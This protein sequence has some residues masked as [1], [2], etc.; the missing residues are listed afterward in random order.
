MT[1][2]TY[3][4]ADQTRIINQYAHQGVLA[5]L[6]FIGRNQYQIETLAIRRAITLGVTEY[7]DQ[8]FHK[9]NHQLWRDTMEE[10]A[11]GVFYRSLRLARDNKDIR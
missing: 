7:G 8:S 4:V 10:C 3:S 6:A 5:L 2:T 1:I 9:T 11:D